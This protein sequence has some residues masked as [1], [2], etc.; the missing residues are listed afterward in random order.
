MM[1]D[2]MEYYK[3]QQFTGFLKLTNVSLHK[4]TMST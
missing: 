1:C 4:F 2:N 3:E